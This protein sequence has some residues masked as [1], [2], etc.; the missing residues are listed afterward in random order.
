MSSIMKLIPK[1]KGRCILEVDELLEI[2]GHRDQEYLIGIIN[3]SG[4]TRKGFNIWLFPDMESAN[5]FVFIYN[6]KYD[7]D[8]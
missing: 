3:D 8:Y 4:A 6:L 1:E 7:S 5:E 2:T